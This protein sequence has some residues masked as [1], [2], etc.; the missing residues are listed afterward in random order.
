M[1]LFGKKKDD[2]SLRKRI[3]HVDHDRSGPQGA[4]ASDNLFKKSPSVSHLHNLHPGPENRDSFYAFEDYQYTRHIPPTNSYGNYDSPTAPSFDGGA[5]PPRTAPLPPT[6]RGQPPH[7][8]TARP[9]YYE[10]SPQLGQA[11]PLS[12]EFHQV[13]NYLNQPPVGRTYSEPMAMG[14]TAHPSHASKPAGRRQ[15]PPAPPSAQTR[16]ARNPPKP[17]EMHT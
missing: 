2:Q 7:P 3:V 6:S 9:G 11:D 17:T 15:Y 16:T 5:H 10:S 12:N 1:G 8:P 14:E 4:M 13:Q